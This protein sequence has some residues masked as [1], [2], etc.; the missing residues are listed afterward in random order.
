VDCWRKNDPPKRKFSDVA[1][2]AVGN[3][4]ISSA[5][6]IAR[7][8]VVVMEQRYVSWNEMTSYIYGSVTPVGLLPV[9]TVM[10]SL[11]LGASCAQSLRM[12][13]YI[14]IYI[15]I[16]EQVILLIILMLQPT[17]H[18]HGR[19]LRIKKI[20]VDNEATVYVNHTF[21]HMHAYIF[22]CTG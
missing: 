13:I 19:C 4:V 3:A 9:D 16:Y 7:M 21:V 6:G 17:T 11:F 10:I 5:W 14:Y 18:A 20:P 22:V 12:Q 1:A 15:S 8:V 2:A